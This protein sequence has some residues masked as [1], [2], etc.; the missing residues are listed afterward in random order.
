MTASQAG[1]STELERDELGASLVLGV[2]PPHLLGLFNRAGVL[3]PADV[4]VALRLARLGGEHHP[5]VVLAAALAVRAPRL[6]HVRVDLATVRLTAIAGDGEEERDLATL[7]WPQPAQWLARVRASPLVAAGEQ[8]PGDRPLRLVDTT[9]YLDR[10]W[11]DEVAVAEHILTRVHNGLF[12]GEEGAL[13]LG[14]ARLFSEKGSDEQRQAAESAVRRRFSVIAG[15]PGT[16][17]TTTVARLLALLHQQCSGHDAMN[18]PPLIALAAPTA[19]AAARMEEA[20]YAEAHHLDTAP[21]VRDWLCSLRAS[22]LHRLLGPDPRQANRFRH[23]RH[24]HLPHDVVIVDETSMVALWLMAR[25]AEAVRPDARLVLVGDPE[26]LASVEAGAVLGDIV[27]PALGAAA[28]GPQRAPNRLSATGP[29]RPPRQRPAPRPASS[30]GIGPNITVLRVNH[31]SHGILAELSTAIR[32]GDE[33]RTVAVLSSGDPAARWLRVDVATATA[34][35][36]GAVFDAAEDCATRLLE[37]ARAGDRGTALEELGRFR[38]LCAHRRG[39][40]GVSTW[41]AAVEERLAANS[42]W[43]SPGGIWYVGRPLIVTANDYSLRLYNGD[44]GVV[45]AGTKGTEAV[46]R[47]GSSVMSVSPFRLPS[48]DTVFAM[49]IHKSQGSEFEETAVLLPGP[50]SRILTRELLLTAVTRARRCLILAGSEEAVRAAVRRP[51]ARASGL[52]RRL[53]GEAGRA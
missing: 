48:A 27:G 46:F 15:G 4:H 9:L 17:K 3:I 13:S 12:E 43:F 1:L 40:T 50:T 35:E 32:E 42:V 34:A 39:P 36:L 28:Q 23:N 44:C 25:L 19:K 6:G 37:A 8:G 21:E 31:R 10:H 29:G 52:T 14:L 51:I 20:I 22:T 45:L 33:D 47:R 24:N 41:N 5:D 38:L 16:G 30:P 7:P 53:W 18:C 11:Q 49:T 2:P 26:Q